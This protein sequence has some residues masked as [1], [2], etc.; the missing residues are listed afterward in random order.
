M[1]S[2]AG[3]VPYQA[4]LYRDQLLNNDWWTYNGYIQDSFS[5]GKWRVNGGIRYDW[6]TS[7]YLGGC[8]APSV[9]RPDLMPSQCENATSVDP[10]TGKKIQAFSNWAPRLSITYD[11]FGNGKTSAHASYSYYYATKIT[12]ANSLASRGRNARLDRMAPACLFGAARCPPTASPVADA[13]PA[14]RSLS[15]R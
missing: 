13:T 1:G 8:I 2:A 4:V 3:I 11:L 7:K 12:L 10:T 5:R 14:S 9:L 6:Q 15:C